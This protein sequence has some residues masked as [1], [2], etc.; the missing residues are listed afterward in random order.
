MLVIK[1]IKNKGICGNISDREPPD[2]S[3]QTQAEVCLGAQEKF[4]RIP[5][6]NL[7]R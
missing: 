3:I 5:T 2:F 6:K 4:G 1:R 7:Y